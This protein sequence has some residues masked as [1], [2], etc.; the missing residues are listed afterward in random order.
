[1]RQARMPFDAAS[2]KSALAKIAAS[3]DGESALA[4]VARKERS[5]ILGE[6]SCWTVNVCLLSDVFF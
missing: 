4:V 5:E 3:G 1:M 2:C 6:V